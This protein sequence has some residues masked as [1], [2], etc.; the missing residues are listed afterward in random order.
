METHRKSVKR[1]AILSLLRAVRC[2]PT[3][4]WVHSELKKTYPDLSL[5]T[6]YRNLRTLTDA[7][8]I[9]SVGV[10]DGQERFDGNLTRHGHF[11]CKRCGA[12]LDVELPG[13][14]FAALG[15]MPQGHVTDVEVRLT[16]L[17]RS[18]VEKDIQA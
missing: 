11:V 3:A 9:R 15:D 10:V 7:G 8:L 18:C 12:V 4:E 17:C 1:D 14:D 5:G 6:V 13:V 16:G 2:H